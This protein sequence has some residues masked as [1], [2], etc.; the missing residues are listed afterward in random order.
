M[1]E[2]EFNELVAKAE[3]G[4]ASAAELEALEPYRA[5]RVVFMAAGFGSR[6]VPLTYTTPKPLAK[7]HGKRLI[8]TTLD[9]ALAAGIEEIYIVRGY[10]A[11]CFDVLLEKY[12]MIHFIEN[13]IYN[14]TNNISSILKAAELLQ[15]AY[16]CE[17]DLL[18]S[19]PKLIT[20]Y[21]YRSNFLGVPTQKTDDWCFTTDGEDGILSVQKG[22]DGG[23]FHMFGISWWSAEDG[24]RLCDDIKDVFENA[25]DGRNVFF[26]AV[27]LTLCRDHYHVHVRRCS[28]DDIVEI[29]TFEELK[30]LEPS[31][32][33]LENSA[34]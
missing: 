16:V 7:V 2:Q 12:P 18:L 9:A 28:F 5:K 11:E 23:V 10:L 33:S 13:P 29:D 1:T 15:N 4:T 14:E 8:E 22:G 24:K 34:V 6:M 31:Y 26:E 20:R 19:N 21:Q 27:P 32:E 3:N 17:A 25:P 30:Q